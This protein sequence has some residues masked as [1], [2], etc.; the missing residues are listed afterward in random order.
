[1]KNLFTQ[2]VKLQK[3]VVPVLAGAAAFQYFNDHTSGHN[4]A[5]RQIFHIWCVTLH[6]TFAVFV[7][8]VT[9]FSA[10]TLC[11]QCT[12]TS[13][14]GGMELPHFHILDFISCAKCHACAIASVHQRIGR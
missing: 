7:N 9:T 8:Q 11:Y 3:D 2:M 12:S 10:T 6:E 14:P 13:N 5:A 1:M 4:I